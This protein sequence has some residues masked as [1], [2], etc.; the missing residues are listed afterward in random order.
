MVVIA[1]VISFF[2]RNWFKSLE[3]ILHRYFFPNHAYALIDADNT[4]NYAYVDT[5][6]I[7]AVQTKFGLFKFNKALQQYYNVFEQIEEYKVD[8]L[9]KSDVVLDIGA[10]VGVF[11]VLAAKSVSQVVA[12]E[13]LFWR[14]LDQNIKLN[15]LNNVVSLPCAL[16]RTSTMEISFCNKKEQVQCIEIP[17]IKKRLGVKPTFLKTDCEGGEWSLTPDDFEGIRAVEAEV[18]NFNH[19]NPM[20]FV[21][22]LQDL[23]FTCNYSW[24]KEK[25]LMVSARK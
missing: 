15:R 22:M 19:K 7:E 14:E 25:Q 18:H 8:D 20:D 17:E 16:G 2:N 5:R 23:G 10:N 13:P 24:T 21:R 12:V 3:H 9:K 4:Y 11:T 6:L 1:N